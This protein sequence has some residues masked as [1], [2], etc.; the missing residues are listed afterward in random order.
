MESYTVGSH[1]FYLGYA[2][3]H[4][5]LLTLDAGHYHPRETIAD[6]ISAALLFVSE[7]LLHVSRG[8]WNWACIA[9]RPKTYRWPKR[10]R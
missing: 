2:A 7:I 10:R 3:T 9:T 5:T 8:V 4:H 1:E 6:K